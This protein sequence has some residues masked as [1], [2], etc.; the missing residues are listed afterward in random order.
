MLSA[1]V[2]ILCPLWSLI[3]YPFHRKSLA[4]KNLAGE[5][6]LVFVKL[7]ETARLPSRFTAGSA[8]LDVCPA[9]TYTIPPGKTVAC[10]TGLSVRLP[11]GTFGRLMT[12]SSTALWDDLKVVG[13]IID[14]DFRGEIFV[15]LHNDS[16][17]R[18]AFITPRHKIA[19]L[20]VEKV[21]MLEPVFREPVRLP[22]G[23]ERPH[24]YKEILKL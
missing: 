13:G 7:K 18:P 9:D 11:K 16:T 4:K 10:F 23:E 2:N 5:K 12:R 22:N 17:N 15:L 24:E 8:G 21:E 14:Q 20:I 19:Q 6:Q 1:V 3:T